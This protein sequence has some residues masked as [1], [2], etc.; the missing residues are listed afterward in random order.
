MP[1]GT[2]RP[3]RRSPPSES[4]R[5]QRALGAALAEL[6]RERGL[7]Q[8]ALADASGVHLT[9]I[10]AVE[11]GRRN[12]SW[13]AVRALVAGFGDVSLSEFGRAVERHERATDENAG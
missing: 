6:R 12:P 8:E 11:S 13:A 7:T 3:P 4:A 10:S 2:P 9:W 1:K 5:P